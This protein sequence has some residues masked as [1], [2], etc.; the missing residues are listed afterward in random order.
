MNPLSYLA[1]GT[2]RLYQALA[3]ARIRSKCRFEPSCSN[4]AAVAFQK[5]SFTQAMKKTIHRLGR[6]KYPNGGIDYP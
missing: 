6:C 3:P 1:L 2:I 4:Y 5:Y